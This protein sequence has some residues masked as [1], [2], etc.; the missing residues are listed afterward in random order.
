[1][2]SKTYTTSLIGVDSFIIEIEIDIHKGVPAFNMV[3]LPDTVVKES[4]E[5]VRSAIKNS[6]YEFPLKKITIN[7]APADVK[8][9]GSYYDLAIAIGIMISNGDIKNDYIKDCIFIGELSLNGEIRSVKGVLPMVIEAKRSKYKKIFIPIQNCHEVNIIDG[10]DIYGVS[11]LFELISFLNGEIE[12]EKI[13]TEP[14]QQL[15]MKDYEVDFSEVIGQKFAKRAVEITASGYHNLLMIGPPGGG[16]TM[17][18]QRIPTILPQLTYEQAIEVTKIYSISGILKDNSKIIFWPPFRNPHHTSSV[19]SIIGGGSNVIPGEVSLAHNGVLFFDELPE[20]KRDTLEALR[21]PLEDG[22]VSI[23]RAKGKYTFPAK[24]L[25]VASMNPCPCGYYG[26]QLKECSCSPTQIKNYLSKVSGPLLDRIDIHVNI[27]PIN[28]QEISSNKKEESSEEI[29]KR[30]IRVREIQ[31]IRFKDDDINYNSQ[32][33]TKHIKKYC[34]L[35]EKGM[36]LLESAFKALTLSTRAYNKILKIA[37]TIADMDG[38]DNIKDDHI[39]EAIQYR[40][41]DRKYWV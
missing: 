8:K 14:Y 28:F 25:L 23:S 15:K 32:M 41:L 24:F 38:S 39:A 5:R 11:T 27:E 21:Q 33:R 36:K 16:K 40:T 10:I 12:L 2:I 18:A 19:I 22:I 30:V 1:M 35:D 17:I 34:K 37:R 7:F 3:G 26:Y 31:K 9:E 29:R 4:K 13:K 20:F 6:G